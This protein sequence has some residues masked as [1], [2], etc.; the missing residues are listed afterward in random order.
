MKK[1]MML[2]MVVL[3]MVSLCIPAA[4]VAGSFVT[5]P[6]ANQ[7]P[8]LISAENEKCDAEIVITA[9]ANR[10]QLPDD[11][12]Q[13]LENAYADIVGTEDLSTLNK[14]ITK[15]ANKTG[16]YVSE[17]AVSD[18]FDVSMTDC[19]NHGDHGAFD[20]VLSAETLHNFVCLLQYHNGEWSVVENAEISKDGY[21]MFSQDEVSPLAIVTYTGEQN[22]QKD[23]SAPIVGIIVASA[24]TAGV[25]VYLGIKFNTFTK[26]ASKLAKLFAK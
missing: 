9:Y 24:S 19:G 10:A 3:M 13:A 1:F 21:L 15:I 5:S 2:C 26:A 4:A 22:I 20:I 14:D 7:A 8:E 11:K 6:S 12:R 16:V 18:L 23:E 25:G 17:L